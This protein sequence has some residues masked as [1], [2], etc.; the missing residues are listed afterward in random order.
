MEHN[1]FVSFA[2]GHRLMLSPRIRLR[3]FYQERFDPMQ[4]ATN[5]L[6][7]TAAISASM[8][9]S[10]AGAAE[11]LVSSDITVSTTWTKNNVYN[12]PG[13]RYLTN[14]ATLTVEA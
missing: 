8:I 9:G 3:N 6:A 2:M 4:T 1:W 7:L 12:L 13:A 10:I 11:V 5:T 14:G